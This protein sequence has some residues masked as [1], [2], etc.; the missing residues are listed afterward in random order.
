MIGGQ[1]IIIDR[2]AHPGDLSTLLDA[3]KR[4]WPGAMVEGS[5]GPPD[6]YFV[7][8]DPGTHK[9]WKKWGKLEEND[10]GMIQIVKDPTTITLVVGSGVEALQ[11]AH[12]IIDGLGWQLKRG[13]LEVRLTPSEWLRWKAWYDILPLFQRGEAYG[14]AL[15]YTRDAEPGT[16]TLP[17]S[18]DSTVIFKWGEVS[19]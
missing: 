2:A 1:D 3:I 14:F 15:G 19:R 8:R 10:D 9:S 5:V 4:E 7:Y 13:E 17:A 18:L 11:F 16:A 6:I 12:R